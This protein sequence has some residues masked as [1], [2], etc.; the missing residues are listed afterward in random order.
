VEDGIIKVEFV[1]SIDND[2]NIFAKNVS[3]EIYQ[4]HV[5]KFL[6]SIEEIGSEQTFC[7]RKGIGNIPHVH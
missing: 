3:Q 7:H 1:K 6:G 2:S 4:K 5:K